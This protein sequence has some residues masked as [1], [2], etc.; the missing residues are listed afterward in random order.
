[1]SVAAQDRVAELRRAVEVS[2][3][4]ES[5]RFE[6]AQALLQRQEFAAAI[7]TLNAARKVFDKSP[8]IE[9]ALGV[10]YYG[11]RR[12]PEA[13]DSFLRTIRIAPAIEQP[14][15]FLARMIEQTGDR[16]PEVAAKFA[17]FATANPNSY[18]GYYLQA[19]ALIAQGQDAEKL[20]RKA[21]ALEDRDAEL[22]FELGA[23]LDQKRQWTEAAREFAR[24]AELNP[25]N[26]AAHYRLARVYDRLGKRADARRERALHAGLTQ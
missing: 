19:K 12:F 1:M 9:L 15:I 4:D 13:V 25:K 18:L 5:A 23:L 21:L 17:A 6:L 10:A 14:Y 3:Y 20:L 16:L 26:A 2:P 11:Q 8:Q 7:E 22:H 24:C